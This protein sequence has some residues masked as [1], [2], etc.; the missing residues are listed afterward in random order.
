M[1]LARS[2]R[3][4]MWVMA[5]IIVILFMIMLPGLILGL[6]TMKIAWALAISG[7]VAPAV[8]F[9]AGLYYHHNK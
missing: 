2:K 7:A 9:F 8:V 5:L 6:V 4:W 3:T 1:P